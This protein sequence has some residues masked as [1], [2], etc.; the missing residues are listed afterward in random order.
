MSVMVAGG[1]G[2]ACQHSEMT[3]GMMQASKYL[4]IQDAADSYSTCQPEK[5]RTERMA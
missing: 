1:G 3:F 2:C 5:Q 4:S